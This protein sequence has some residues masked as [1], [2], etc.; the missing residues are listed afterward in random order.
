MSKR[1]IK[2]SD[3]LI[4]NNKRVN[5]VYKQIVSVIHFMYKKE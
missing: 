4:S 5:A 3:T 2:S 1:M